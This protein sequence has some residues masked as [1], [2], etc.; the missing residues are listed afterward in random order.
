MEGKERRRNKEIGN[1]VVMLDSEE[2]RNWG[3]Y[4]SS[5]PSS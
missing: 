2:G 4:L 1:A 5:P 3:Q